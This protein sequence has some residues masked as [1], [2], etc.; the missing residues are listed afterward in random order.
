MCAFGDFGVLGR[1]GLWGF[2]A[3][4]YVGLGAWLR[5]K[6]KHSSGPGGGDPHS[7]VVR[8]FPGA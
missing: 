2:Q 7:L 3:Y 5:Q 6:G 1:S 4:A 8:L